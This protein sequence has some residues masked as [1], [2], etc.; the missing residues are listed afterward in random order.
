MRTKFGLPIQLKTQLFPKYFKQLKLFF[1]WKTL[2][3]AK[4]CDN[5][6]CNIKIEFFIERILLATYFHTTRHFATAAATNATSTFVTQHSTSRQ[7][8]AL[9]LIAVCG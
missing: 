2:E 5:N 7:D 4:K 3:E 6:N 9:E 8:S 1:Q